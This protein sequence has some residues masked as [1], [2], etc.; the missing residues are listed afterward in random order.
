MY[1]NK[2]KLLLIL[3]IIS[4]LLLF[5][6]VFFSLININN[7][8]ILN[9]IYIN[10]INV[11]GLSKDEAFS[12]LFDICKT[13]SDNNIK[14]STSDNSTTTTFDYLG[15]EYDIN[16]AISKAYNIGHSNNIF[17]NNFQI[18]N[19]FFKRKNINLSFSFTT[20]SVNNLISEI[21][22]NLP[23][24]LVQSGYYI[25][26]KK[27]IITKGATGDIVD[28]DKFISDLSSLLENISSTDN[29]ISVST[30][31]ASPDLIDIE[32][33]YNDIHKEA[34]DAYYEKDPFKVYPE[35]VGIS[36]D[37]D[38]AYNLLE[39]DQEEYIIDLNYTYPQ[40]TINDLGINI[41]YNKLSSFTTTYDITNKDRVNNLELAASKLNG[42]ILSPGEEFSYNSIVGARTI[43]NGYKEAKIYANGKVVDGLGGGICQVSSTLY[44]AAV[45]ANLNITERYN[46]QFL[47]S[48]VDPGRDATVVYG[49]KDLKFVNNRS[50]PI[51]IEVKVSNGIVS[52]SIYGLQDDNKYDIT[53]DV[54]IISTK[55]PQVKYEYDSSITDDTEHIKQN[56]TNGMTVN[57]YK[58]VKLDGKILSKDFVSQDTY[59]SL[60][61]VIVKK[62]ESN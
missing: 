51:K 9:N 28:S 61:R 41:F 35:C 15:I 62:S 19:L 53:F 57:V 11:S 48:Y 52:C 45:F 23:N 46:H 13:K 25:E 39:N 40:I 44:N 31:K 1:K 55:E 2:K 21:S 56:G 6:S 4:F 16:E 22:A 14:V 27:L 24:K 60:D 32:K 7:S 12:T 30:K 34:T 50:F 5:F 38:S 37:K 10:N 36:F 49:V 59:N 8:N 43:S 54:E 29:I 42:K 20:D 17:K 18:I 47:T 58:V 3:L 26:N 33:I